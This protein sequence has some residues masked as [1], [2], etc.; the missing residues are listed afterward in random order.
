MLPGFQPNSARGF[1]S[2]L[3]SWMASTADSLP[4]GHAVAVP[5]TEL[6]RKHVGGARPNA[7]LLGS[8]AALTGLVHLDSVKRAIGEAFPGEVGAANIAAAVGGYEFVITQE[9]AASAA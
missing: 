4:K 3:N 8:F 7:A 9:H 2:V 1:C 5:A 6:A